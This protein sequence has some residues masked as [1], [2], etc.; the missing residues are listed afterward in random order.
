M[1]KNQNLLCFTAGKPY[2]PDYL[3]HWEGGTYGKTESHV[4]C[5]RFK[6]RRILCVP[7]TGPIEK[8]LVPD[9]CPHR[10]EQGDLFAGRK[11]GEVTGWR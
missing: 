10:L 3:D 5:K 8:I 7:K 11:P 6:D 2:C 9:E 1:A 4:W